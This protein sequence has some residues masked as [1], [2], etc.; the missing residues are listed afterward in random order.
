MR[1][2]QVDLPPKPYRLLK[3]DLAA[4]LSARSSGGITYQLLVDTTDT[5]QLHIAVT[6][7]EGGGLWSKEAVRLDSIEAV[8]D[9][10]AAIVA[11]VS[12]DASSR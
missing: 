4:K 12:S 10:Y 5:P 9:A 6:A 7:N 11:D 8:I 2:T 1:Y 3:T